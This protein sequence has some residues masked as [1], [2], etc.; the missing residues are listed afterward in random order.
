MMIL[1]IVGGLALLFLGGELLVRGSV[2]IARRFGLSELVI[3]ITL[4]GFGT[5]V[6][7]LVTSLQ[8]IDNDSVGIA[9]GNVVGSNIANVLLILGVT[10]ILSPILVERGALGRDSV[11]MVAATLVLIALI[12]LDLF[13]RPVGL[14]LVAALLVYL[15]AS[16]ILDHGS[17][18]PVANMHRDEARIA[19]SD[20]TLLVASFFA[21]LGLGGLILGA[22][23]LVFGTIQLAEAAGLSESVI[24]LTLV[25]VGTSLPELA[26]S[27][28]AAFRGKASVA[29]G[30][31]IGSN[32]FNALGIVGVTAALS[33]FSVLT[34]RPAAR[35]ILGSDGEAQGQVALPI[36]G[37]EYIGALILS[38]FLML[39]FAFTG[40]R[41]ARWEGIVLLG[42][43]VVYLGLLFDFVPT[44]LAVGG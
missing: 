38:V 35:S 43:Y 20:M 13:T 4:V 40:R 2:G 16:V 1:M 36:I 12:W 41:L 29:L 3:G 10:A 33:P 26:T 7:E 19:A 27:V 14:A 44:P 28:L 23:I 11:V 42:T 30:N 22:R 21:L 18:S 32:I 17:E 15:A 37:W 8:A 39:L 6:P 9:L 5:S 24:G 31:V 25:A 34:E